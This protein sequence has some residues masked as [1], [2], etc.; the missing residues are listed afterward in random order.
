MV[1]ITLSSGNNTSVLCDGAATTQTSQQIARPNLKAAC[2]HEELLP[3]NGTSCRRLSFVALVSHSG[4]LCTLLAREKERER[5]RRRLG[6]PCLTVAK[7]S[8]HIHDQLAMSKH[9][10]SRIRHARPLTFHVARNQNLLLLL[11]RAI[12]IIIVHTYKHPLRL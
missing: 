2:V 11:H 3:Q 9:G 7:S 5:Q 10:N 1:L 6:S 12:I 8:A 4:L